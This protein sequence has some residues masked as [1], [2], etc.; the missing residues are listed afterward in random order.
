[1]EKP[2]RIF[3]NPY[4]VFKYLSGK[5]LMNWMPDEYYLKLMFRATTGKNLNLDDPTMFNEKLQWLKLNNRNPLYTIM[6]DKVKVKEYVADILGEQYIIPTLGVWDNVDD[7]DFT[8]LPNR[9][10]IKCNHNSGKGM[11]I[12]RDKSKMDEIKVRESLKQGMKEDYFKLG[13]E[14]PYKFVKRKVLAEQYMEDGSPIVNSSPDI[15]CL[16]DYKIFCFGGVPKL[17]Q[18]I[19]DRANKEKIDFYDTNWNRIVGLVGLTAGVC[20]SEI[21]IPR[22]HSLD[23]MLKGASILSERI[24]FSRIDFYDINGRAYFGEITFFPASGFGS[25]YPDKW[26]HII[27]EWVNIDFYQW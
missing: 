19:S 21:S 25:F 4:L 6:V 10:V 22:P 17:I 18:V 14:W 2:L 16:R 13:R 20:N 3:K 27:G 11:Y 9:F 8:T 7:I 23:E 15:G 24:P 26:N 5:G 1:M 12:C